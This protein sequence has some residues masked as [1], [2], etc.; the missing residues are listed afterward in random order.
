MS[1]RRRSNKDLLILIQ[2]GLFPCDLFF[3]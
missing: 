1:H 2:Q 3:L